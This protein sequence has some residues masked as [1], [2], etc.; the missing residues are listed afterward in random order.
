MSVWRLRVKERKEKGTDK[1]K[2]ERENTS[3][4]TQ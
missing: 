3:K 4:Q 1:G 2:R